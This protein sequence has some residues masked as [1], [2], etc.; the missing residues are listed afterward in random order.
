MWLI[1]THN[2]IKGVKPR[3]DINEYPAVKAH[4]DQYWDKISTRADK[5]DTPYNLRNCT[6][7]D[8]FFQPKIVY[9]ELARTGNAF[10][11][12]TCNY[13]VGCTGYI[14]TIPNN[15]KDTLLYLLAFLNSRVTLYCLNQITSRFD[16]NGWRWQRQ[17]VEQ[18]RIPMLAD[19][20]RITA[21]VV[22][23]NRKNQAKL[24]EAINAIV[25]DIYNL[26]KEEV[27]F[28]NKRLLK[29]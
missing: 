11:I 4:L 16:E 9:A 6:Y 14:I 10:T 7:M 12:D 26:T 17:F 2:G 3:I 22:K 21:E 8:L 27:D 28:I 18:L 15:D 20:N 13:I 19:I 1:N 25:T 24:S 29:Y 5:G 23:V